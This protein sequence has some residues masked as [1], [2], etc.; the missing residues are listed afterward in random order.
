LDAKTLKSLQQALSDL[1][2][3]QQMVTSAITTIQT[4]LGA[5][6]TGSRVAAPSVARAATAPRAAGRRKP[7]WSPAMRKAAKERMKRYW[8]QRRK[9][10]KG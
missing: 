7:Q 4:L 1:V 5:R 10:A 6:T 3:E 9:G 2:A 8:D